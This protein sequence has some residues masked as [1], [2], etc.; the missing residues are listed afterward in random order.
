MTR[1]LFTFCFA[2]GLIV[3]NA[4]LG[5]AQDDPAVTQPGG[6]DPPPPVPWAIAAPAAGAK[7]QI[8]GTANPIKARGTFPA[9]TKTKYVRLRGP[10]QEDRTRT[11][12]VQL[13]GASHNGAW[14]MDFPPPGGEGAT[15][16]AGGY[17]IDIGQVIII[18][19]YNP[20]TGE[21]KIT[22]HFFPK[23]THNFTVEV[24]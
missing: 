17:T 3:L 24:P 1:L 11:V 20:I 4:S 23:V 9:T 16:A 21:T 10:V 2:F 22:Y 12:Q 8:A 5:F 19:T 6:Q 15:W 14:S 18:Q 13:F 7:L